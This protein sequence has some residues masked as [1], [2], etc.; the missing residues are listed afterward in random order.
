MWVG[1]S[2]N[3]HVFCCGE[4]CRRCFLCGSY[5]R[6]SKTSILEPWSRSL[7]TPNTEVA[8]AASI[9]YLLPCLDSLV[10]QVSDVS[11]GTPPILNP[12]IRIF[13]ENLQKPRENGSGFRKE[14]WLKR[15]PKNVRELATRS[16]WRIRAEPGDDSRSAQSSR[17]LLDCT[18][19]ARVR[20]EPT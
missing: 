2:L 11:R 4:S 16:V 13:L 3:C 8:T 14:R 10:Q 7:K 19:S 12:R 1:E 20:V 9:G 18:S 15:N 5:L 17:V 6:L